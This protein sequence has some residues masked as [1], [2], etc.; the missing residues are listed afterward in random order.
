MRRPLRHLD[1]MLQYIFDMFLSSEDT[2]TLCW[3]ICGGGKLEQEIW[4]AKSTLSKTL[5]FL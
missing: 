4:A 2:Q 3:V 1:D 5:H